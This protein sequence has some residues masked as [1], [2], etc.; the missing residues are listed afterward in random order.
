VKSE[1]PTVSTFL[2]IIQSP[3]LV[4]FVHD[5]ILENY[6]NVSGEGRS[7]NY[8][9]YGMWSKSGKGNYDRCG[10]AFGVN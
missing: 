1:T 4:D 6:S 10:K 5:Y 7:D 8:V 3:Q 2:A 9:M